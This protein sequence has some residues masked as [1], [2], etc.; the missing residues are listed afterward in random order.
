MS[1]KLIRLHPDDCVAVALQSMTAG[2][3]LEWGVGSTTETIDRGHKVALRDIAAGQWVRKYQQPIGQALEF[4]ACGSHVHSHNLAM[5]VPDF[6]DHNVENSNILVETETHTARTFEGF[7]RHGDMPVHR[8]VGTRNYVGVVATVSCAT[9]VC[10][11]VAATLQQKITTNYPGLDGA[12]ALT[13]G[14]GCAIDGDGEG[15]A[16]LQNTLA[17]WI[18]HPNFAGILVVSL[19]CETNQIES[20]MHSTGLEHSD[21]LHSLVIQNSGGSAS[22]IEQGVKTLE[23]LLT[24][25]QSIKRQSLPL[26]YLKVAL[27]CGGSDGFSGISANPALGVAM[28]KLIAAGGTAILS[29]T[30]EIYGAEH[31]LKRRA[32]A[33]KI[34]EA[35]QA[36]VDWWQHYVSQQGGSL[37][38]NPSHGNKAGGLT[39]ILEKSLGAIAKAGSTPVKA[40]YDYAA[41]IDEPGLVFM[42]SPGYDPVSITGQVASGANLICFTTGRGSAYGCKPV[43]SIKLA[44]NSALW[45]RMPGD[46][47]VNCGRLIDG[48]IELETLGE[49]ILEYL[50]RVAS[51]EATASEQLDIGDDAFLPW[52]LGAVL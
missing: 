46:M 17:G 43:P 29:E 38:H 11:R 5:A 49:E 36:K 3:P 7:L 9:N 12:V 52:S 18:R 16:L 23:P 35:I 40:V 8:R 30:P 25:W 13:H 31:L 15:L 26:Q 6:H 14:G 27:Q 42:D 50:I 51:G 45:Q 47:D 4:I 24:Q 21:R 10:K 22:S 28:D 2:E 1:K 39:T 34:A 37:D 19:G 20:L 41:P 32:S 48:S 33:P 44:S